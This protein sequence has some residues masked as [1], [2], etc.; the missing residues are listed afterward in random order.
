MGCKVS[1]G[2]ILANVLLY[3]ASDPIKLL[4]AVL[5]PNGIGA[6]NELIAAFIEICK[7]G[8]L[9][10]EVLFDLFIKGRKDVHVLAATV[11]LLR[12]RVGDSSV[13]TLLKCL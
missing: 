8:R 12:L 7:W 10:I 11:V 13:K 2:N 1:W 5:F 4:H 6:I 3:E 9:R